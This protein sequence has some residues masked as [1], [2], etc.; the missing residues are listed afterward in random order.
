MPSK[1]KHRN[2]SNESKLLEEAV[3]TVTVSTGVSNTQPFGHHQDNRKKA[4]FR[5]WFEENEFRLRVAARVLTT[6]KWLVI[7]YFC[8]DA[9]CTLKTIPETVKELVSEAIKG[10]SKGAEEAADSVKEVSG[11]VAHTFKDLF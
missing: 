5:D 8:Y 3:S 2:V 6:I 10:I 1:I 7:I 9:Y 4:S 11:D